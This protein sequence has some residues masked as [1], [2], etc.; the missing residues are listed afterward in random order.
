M[1]KL[2][3]IEKARI[4]EYRS[5]YKE[6]VIEHLTNVIIEELKFE[7]W[8]CGIENVETNVKEY[9]E[10]KGNFWLA[11]NENDDAA[12]TIGLR[13]VNEEIAE[14]KYFYLKEDYRGTG[15]AQRLFNT[16]VDFAKL[17]KYKKIILYTCEKCGRAIN[18]YKKNNFIQFERIV[19]YGG[20]EKVGKSYV[21]EKCI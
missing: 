10:K 14:I 2:L 4:I 8:R 6:K 17:N 21:F 7:D 5:E 12:G 16:C 9:I 18:F 1:E 15:L 3:E 11:I 19:N 20:V 13:I